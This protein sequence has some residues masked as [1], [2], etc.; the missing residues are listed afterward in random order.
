M[1]IYLWTKRENV[2]NLD[3]FLNK[4]NKALKLER[5]AL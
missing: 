3:N 5:R 2:D 1:N 4:R